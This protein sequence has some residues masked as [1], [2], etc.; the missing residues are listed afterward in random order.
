MYSCSPVIRKV[1]PGNALQYESIKPQVIKSLEQAIMVNSP[2]LPEVRATLKSPQVPAENSRNVLHYVQYIDSLADVTEMLQDKLNDIRQ[3]RIFT[4]QEVLPIS[5]DS[6]EKKIATEYSKIQNYRKNFYT[7]WA[8]V[9]KTEYALKF[10]KRNLDKVGKG[11]TVDK[12]LN[13]KLMANV[14]FKSGEHYTNQN[15]LRDLDYTIKEIRKS[16]DNYRKEIPQERIKLKVT[17]VG[18]ADKKPF[19]YGQPQ[20]EREIQNLKMSQLRAQAVADYIRKQLEPLIDNI[21]QEVQ[22]AG[23][24]LPPTLTEDSPY[25]DP[26]RRVC[27]VDLFVYSE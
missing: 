19:Y 16:I 24:A 5:L 26:R 3:T 1:I 2:S 9:K 23:E 11:Y 25:P 13:I 6:L 18:Y 20:K 7:P 22:G 10:I 21:S 12:G 27:V 14:F 8:D 17:V 15:N 4:A